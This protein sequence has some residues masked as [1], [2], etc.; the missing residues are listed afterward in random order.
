MEHVRKTGAR[1]P[2]FLGQ[3][4]LPDHHHR[5]PWQEQLRLLFGSRCPTL[6]CCF[7]FACNAL[8]QT[9]SN[10]AEFFHTEELLDDGEE[11]EDS[12]HSMV[13]AGFALTRFIGLYSKLC[14]NTPDRMTGWELHS[15][16]HDVRSHSWGNL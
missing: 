4:A 5:E 15:K 9:P 12:A 13:C 2:D 1:G 11:D 3:K 8:M 10:Y 7:K 16:C 6:L 14:F